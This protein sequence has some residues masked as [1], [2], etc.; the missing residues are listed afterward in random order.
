MIFLGNLPGL[1]FVAFGFCFVFRVFVNDSFEGRV[2]WK[3]VAKIEIFQ[4]FSRYFTSN[5]S[6]FRSRI[7]DG[8]PRYPRHRKLP[9]HTPIFLVTLSP[10]C[11]TCAMSRTAE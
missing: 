3:K 7:E 8:Q 11:G 5:T 4:H 9:T 10:S 1:F 2:A 6:D